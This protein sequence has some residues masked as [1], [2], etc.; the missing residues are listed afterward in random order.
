MNDFTDP[1][2]LRC[3]AEASVG[4]RPKPTGPRNRNKDFLEGSTFEKKSTWSE[5][6][7]V[8]NFMT[9]DAQVLDRRVGDEVTYG[10]VEYAIQ[11][12]VDPIL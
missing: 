12:P 10:P 5:A 7:S 2:N 6:A 8:W 9:H 4:T 3:F 1:G 11:G